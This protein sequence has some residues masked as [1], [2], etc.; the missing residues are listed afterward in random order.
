MLGK[1]LQATLDMKETIYRDYGGWSLENINVINY[2][3]ENGQIT[4]ENRMNKRKGREGTERNIVKI[5]FNENYP[6][7]V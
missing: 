5:Y 3:S 6:G 2:D 4:S 7:K 1:N